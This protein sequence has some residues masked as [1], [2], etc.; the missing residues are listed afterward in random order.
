MR[1]WL[2]TSVC[3]ED[4]RAYGLL[5][6]SDKSGGRDFDEA[7]ETNIHEP[8]ALIGETLDALRLPRSGRAGIPRAAPRTEARA[9]YALVGVGQ[10][11]AGTDAASRIRSAVGDRVR[12]PKSLDRKLTA[13]EQAA[14]ISRRASR[15]KL[16]QAITR[17]LGDVADVEPWTTTFNPGR[18]TLDRLVELSQEVDF[19]AFVFA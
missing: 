4:G 7:D 9:R 12:W 1:G 8:A 10:T 3:G 13:L 6:L 5:Q 2:A 17:G 19:A 16:L 11:A 15:P 14:H 18:S